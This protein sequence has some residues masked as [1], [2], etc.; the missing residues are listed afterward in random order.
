MTAATRSRLDR[1]VFLG[2]ATA[3]LM[4]FY[5]LPVI[6]DVAIAFTDMGR[7]LE[8]TRVTTENVARIFG[9]DR[10]LAQVLTNTLVYVV[11]TLTLF[12]VGYALLLALTTT[13]LPDRAGAFFRSVWLLPRMSPSVVYALLWTW[14]V[15]PTEYGLL[16]QIVAG[17]G[18]PPLDL[19]SDAP[20]LVV[21][22]ANGFIGASFGMIIFTSAI[23]SI[24]QHLFYA[25]RAD[26]ANGLQIVRHVTLPQIRWHL[27]FVTLYQALSLLV[28]FEYIWLITDGGP[29][30]DTTVWALYV[31]QRA[32]TSGQYAYGAALALVLVAAGIVAALVLWRFFDMRALLQRPRIEVS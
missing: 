27:S 19:K 29:F 7:N 13:A 4:L 11:C 31:Y 8:V 17:I 3:L 10:R 25:A 24:P 20:M 5:V 21:V 6:V 1:L 12:N 26:G 18:M 23:R 32:F 28:S 16:N 9:G 30:Y 15:A 22:L 14:V 2:P